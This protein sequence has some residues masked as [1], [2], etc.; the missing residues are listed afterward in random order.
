MRVEPLTPPDW[1]PED[2]AT[3]AAKSLA[4]AFNG[5]IVELGDDAV[6]G[7]GPTINAPF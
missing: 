1:T 7:S 4:D 6:D 2:P 3:R 5:T